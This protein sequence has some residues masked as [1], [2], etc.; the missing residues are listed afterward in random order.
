LA[1]PVARRN[2]RYKNAYGITFK[3]YVE[4][5]FRQDNKCLI[6]GIDGKDTDR[7]KLSV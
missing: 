1:D 3:D 6:C 4:I 2:S 5:A 7:G